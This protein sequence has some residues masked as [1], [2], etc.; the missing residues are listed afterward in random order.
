MT[1]HY[2]A[3]RALYYPTD[4]AIVKRLVAGENLRMGE[5]QMREVEAGTIVEDLPEVSVPGLLKAKWI[6]RLPE[7]EPRP[8]ASRRTGSVN[9]REEVSP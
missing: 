6:E 8:A 7:E 3:L 1:V 5:R 2:R 9:P 4:P